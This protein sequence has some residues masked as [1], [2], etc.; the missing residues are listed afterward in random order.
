M[1][2]DSSSRRMQAERGAPPIGHLY[3]VDNKHLMLHRSGSGHPAVVFM[4]GAGMVGLDFLNI[5]ERIS[6][7]ITSVVYDRGGTG[8]SDAV[9]MP[10]SAFEVTDELRSLLQVAGIR[11]PF[12]IV[13]HSLGGAYARRYTQ[14]FPDE[15]AGLLLMEPAVEGFKCT[16]A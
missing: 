13:G 4:P 5:H 7:Y 6:A 12:V 2:Q 1:H 8:W 9:S 11:G 16:Y 3:S 15:V 14:R 10:R